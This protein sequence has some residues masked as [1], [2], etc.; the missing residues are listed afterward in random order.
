MDL[1]WKIMIAAAAL[2]AIG[3]IAYG[4]WEW[5]ERKFEKE[6]PKVRSEKYQQASSSVADYA[7][8]LAEFKKPTY[9]RED[10][11]PTDTKPPQK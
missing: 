9:K 10:A 3:W 5:R 1:F 11:S 7:K 4:I 6:Q 2:V 8:K